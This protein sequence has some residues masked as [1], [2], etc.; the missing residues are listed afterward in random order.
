MRRGFSENV[1]KDARL[2]LME[3]RRGA[4]KIGIP[5]RHPFIHARLQS[6]RVAKKSRL[7]GSAGERT[8]N[9]LFRLRA[10]THLFARANEH[11]RASWPKYSRHRV[12]GC[13]SYASAMHFEGDANSGLPY[14]SIFPPCSDRRSWRGF[15]EISGNRLSRKR[16]PLLY[17]NM[18][19]DDVN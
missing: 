3:Y 15:F 16:I 13:A 19:I 7:P 18:L 10:L 12:S 4:V 1:W 5:N 9:A 17:L 2:S 11:Q 14:L 8:M 6:S